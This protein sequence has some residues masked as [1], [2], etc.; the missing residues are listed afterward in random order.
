MFL[1][2]QSIPHVHHQH[3]MPQNP[4]DKGGHHPHH[5][6]D[7]HHGDETDG[8]FDFLI[9]LFGNHAHSLQSDTNHAV[10]RPAKQKAKVKD[11]HLNSQADSRVEQANDGSIQKPVIEPPPESFKKF[12][13][14]TSFL[15]GPPFLG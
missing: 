10:E 7:H 3:E 15:R 12:Y 6:K 4:M 14:S 2:H 5:E 9:F 1:L 8:L 13:L 11:L